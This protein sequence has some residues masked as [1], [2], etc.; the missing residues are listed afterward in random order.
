MI[1]V[2]KW[3]LVY[4]C[5]GRLSS[6]FPLLGM[7]VTFWLLT[8]DCAIALLVSILRNATN[9]SPALSNAFEMVAAASASPSAR[10]TAA[11][12]SCSA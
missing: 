4:R 7:Y 5:V 11:C 6:T 12:R 2:R 10:I 1:K 3:L 8:S 9:A